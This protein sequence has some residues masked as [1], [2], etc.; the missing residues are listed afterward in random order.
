[1]RPAPGPQAAK[2]RRE[3]FNANFSAKGIDFCGKSLI[4]GLACPIKGKKLTPR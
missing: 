4:C 1:V 3:M 2:P